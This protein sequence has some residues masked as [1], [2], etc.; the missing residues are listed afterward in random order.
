[1][2]IKIIVLC[3]VLSGISLFAQ[4]KEERIRH[5]LDIS[6]SGALTMQIMDTI[7]PEFNKLVPDIPEDFW[8]RFRDK[9]NVDD[10]Y[11]LIIPI[12]NKYYTL[13]EINE[14]IAFYN[15]PLGKKLI[16]TTP[17]ITQESYAAG[18]NWG[19]MLGEQI[20]NELRIEGLL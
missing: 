1:M 12:Y 3:I 16:S 2:K 9:I 7:I 15:T 11:D 8:V 19:R 13:D 18:Q 20:A 14:L 10:F 5:L 4:P 17:I 6:G